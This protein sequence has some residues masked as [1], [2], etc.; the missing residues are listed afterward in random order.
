MGDEFQIVLERPSEG[1]EVLRLLVEP[2]GD[3]SAGGLADRIAVEFRVRF[4]LRADIEVVPPGSL[5]KTEFK[6]KRVRDLRE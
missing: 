5:P 3:A 2:R 4:D 1:A 6:A